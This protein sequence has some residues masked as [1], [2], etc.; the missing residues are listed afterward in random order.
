M[1]AAKAKQN[2]LKLIEDM[3]KEEKKLKEELEREEKI[4]NQ[5]NREYVAA[6]NLPRKEAVKYF[7]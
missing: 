5:A 1:S 4:V 2:K 7:K 6:F 3:E